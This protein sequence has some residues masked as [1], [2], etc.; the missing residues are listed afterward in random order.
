V[1]PSALLLCVFLFF[2]ARSVHAE[3]NNGG[4]NGQ[5]GG[6]PPAD[7]MVKPPSAD[8]QKVTTEVDM[9]ELALK[10]QEAVTAREF[11]EIAYLPPIVNPS[12]RTIFGNTGEYSGELKFDTPT[13]T[14]REN[15]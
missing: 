6:H 1:K 12:D 9:P 10:L 5:L 13:F 4:D 14:S 8:A 3:H 2:L 11:N 15:P 7:D